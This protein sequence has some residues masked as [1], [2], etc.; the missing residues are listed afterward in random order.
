VR[1]LGTDVPVPSVNDLIVKAVALAL[2][3]HPRL[4]AAYLDGALSMHEA[5]NIGVAVATDDALM[6]PTLR[7]ADRRSL[8]SLATETRRLAERV[9]SGQITPGELSG[10]GFTVSNLGMFGMTAIR[11]IINAPQVGI[12][13]VGMAREVL[14]RVGGEIVE[15][16]VMTLTL[17]CD[18]RAVYGADAGRFLS[19]VR[20]LLQAPLRLML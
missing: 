11:P 7:D 19:D 3:R 14:A 12:L 1:D 9:R 13:G 20:D 18:H 2:R 17:S 10:A 15:R 5:V 6:V 8:G 4:N 16:Q